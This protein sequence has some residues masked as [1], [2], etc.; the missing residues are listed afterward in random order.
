MNRFN[1]IFILLLVVIAAGSIFLLAKNLSSPV[2]ESNE[3]KTVISG[4]NLNPSN[5]SIVSEDR[6]L[7]IIKNATFN[8]TW[9]SG[10]VGF[11][12]RYNCADFTRDSVLALR[13]N[14]FTA[15][16][17][18]GWIGHDVYHAWVGVEINGT[19]V[20]IEPQNLQYVTDHTVN[21]T[22][23]RRCVVRGVA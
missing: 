14:N 7:E 22:N 2:K 5:D 15:Y 6:I 16:P 11:E 12:G 10:I 19:L 8:R 18:C 17:M 13:E 4:T 21:Y 1:K 9:T 23:A 3:T 20:Q